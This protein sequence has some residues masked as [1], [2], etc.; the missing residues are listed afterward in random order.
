MEH[1]EQSSR[2][3]G[4]HPGR[5]RARCPL[6]AG[7]WEPGE[8]TAM[9]LCPHPRT[10]IGRW[11]RTFRPL[12]P[13]GDISGQEYS[14][15]PTGR[16]PLA[17]GHWPHSAAADSSLCT[18]HIAQSLALSHS[19]AATRAS[20]PCPWPYRPA[21]PAHSVMRLRPDLAAMRFTIMQNSPD[22]AWPSC[23]FTWLAPGPDLAIR[24]GRYAFFT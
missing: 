3:P 4:R 7:S 14:P 18:S 15:D 9:H 20:R 19:A 12:S 23:L 22:P 6:A 10:D 8:G 5:Q 1:D 2:H 24:P 16:W 17:T 21:V 11:A 13:Q